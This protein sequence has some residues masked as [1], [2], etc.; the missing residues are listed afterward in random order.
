MFWVMIPPRLQVYV[1]CVSA[2]MT[3]VMLCKKLDVFESARGKRVVDAG[4]AAGFMGEIVVG[5]AGYWPWA[6]KEMRVPAAP[7]G[8]YQS[9]WRTSPT[10]PLPL[11]CMAQL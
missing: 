11:R 6:M 5:N 7:L 3:R 4:G 10:R 9:A 8:G 2:N 1:E